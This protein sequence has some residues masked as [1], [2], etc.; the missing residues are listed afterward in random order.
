MVSTG[1]LK[2]ATIDI[3]TRRRL[4][5][6]E[7]D[8][9]SN[10]EINRLNG[11]DNLDIKAVRHVEKRSLSANAY[12]HVLVSKIADALSI[13]KAHAKNDLIT[14]YGQKMF[15]DDDVACIKTNLTIEQTREMEQ[16]HLKFVKYSEQ[17][18]TYF[19]YIYRGSRTYNSKEMSV[20]IE[21]TVM[22][23]KELDIETLPPAELAKMAAV[24][25]AKEE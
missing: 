24:W 12:F 1:R 20:L 18:G 25:E 21:G 16:P 8:N 11:L 17:D 13:S 9:V 22:D 15:T 3:E 10:E 6:F 4:L 14:K 23:A 19:Y 5:T 2:Q 7:V